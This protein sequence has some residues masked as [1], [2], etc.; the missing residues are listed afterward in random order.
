MPYVDLFENVPHYQ[1]FNYIN[2]LIWLLII[3]IT[4]NYNN[5]Y[6][7]HILSLLNSSVIIQVQ[8]ETDTKS[9]FA[10]LNGSCYTRNGAE[11]GKIN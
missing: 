6:I 5:N 7:K 2:T 11:N 10:F 3:R 9:G 4:N 1:Q 8:N